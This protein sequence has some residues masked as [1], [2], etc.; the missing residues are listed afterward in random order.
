[1]Y[2]R[3]SLLVCQLLEE[4]NVVEVPVYREFFEYKAVFVAP[5]GFSWQPPAKIVR[6]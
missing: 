3:E 6:Q 5:A 2:Y 4:F 1:M